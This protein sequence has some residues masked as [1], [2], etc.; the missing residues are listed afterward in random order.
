MIFFDLTPYAIKVIRLNPLMR[1][2]LATLLMMGVVGIRFGV[3]QHLVAPFL[4]LPPQ[5]LISALLF[6]WWV[7]TYV[8]IVGCALAVYLMAPAQSFALGGWREAVALGAFA[9]FCAALTWLGSV[10][11]GSAIRLAAAEGEKDLLLRELNHRIGNDLSMVGGL[12]I[13]QA[14]VASNSLVRQALHQAADRVAVIG[15]V[16]RRLRH[17][18]R[19]AVV[20]SQEYLGGLCQELR[21]TLIGNSPIDLSVE[22]ESAQVSLK[23]AVMIGLIINELVTNAVKY[24][25]PGNQP[26][27]IEVRFR[28]QDKAGELVVCDDGV[29]LPMEQPAGTGLGQLLVQQLAEGMEGTITI[30][31]TGGTFVHVLLPNV[32]LSVEEP[33]AHGPRWSEPMFLISRFPRLEHYLGLYY[34]ARAVCWAACINAVSSRPPK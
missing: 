13:A 28:C 29:G 14:H 21:T 26:G 18:H 12:L 20:D 24:A 33:S 1:Y 23:S 27:Q 3:D 17:G 19:G 34:A 8:S 16:H 25:F 22:V 4:F 11:R 10:L 7:G 30:E 32:C 15:S 9:L 6:G 31:T 5:V 2:L